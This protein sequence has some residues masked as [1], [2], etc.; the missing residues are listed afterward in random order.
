MSQV[1]QNS[2]RYNDLFE[3]LPLSQAGLGRHKC[4]GCAYEHGLEVGKEGKDTFSVDLSNLPDSQAGT[5]RHR[6]PLAAFA[7]GII[8][9]IGS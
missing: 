8:D 6:N 2:H 7:K 9:G 3:N 1:C 4:A 5:V